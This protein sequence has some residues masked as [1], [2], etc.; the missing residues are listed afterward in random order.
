MKQRFGI[1]WLAL[2]T[3]YLSFTTTDM[4]STLR[5]VQNSQESTLYY[6]KK[7]AKILKR[8]K[9]AGLL[10]REETVSLNGS[11]QSTESSGDADKEPRS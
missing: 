5:S 6:M 2:L 10:T 11:A 9:T 4:Y 7:S 1:I 8:I 3:V